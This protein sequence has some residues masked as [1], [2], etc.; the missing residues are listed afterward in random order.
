M[1]KKRSPE[2]APTIAPGLD[3]DAK[4]SQSASEREKREGESTRVT[5][6]SWDEVDPS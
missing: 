4:L 1:E 5:I 3:T 2:N 6:A